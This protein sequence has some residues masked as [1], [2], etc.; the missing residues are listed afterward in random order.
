MFSKLGNDEAGHLIGT[1]ELGSYLH[2]YSNGELEA[3]PV[4]DLSRPERVRAGGQTLVRYPVCGFYEDGKISQDEKVDLE[5]LF[6]QG[7]R[8]TRVMEAVL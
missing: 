8:V 5:E 2:K 4:F 1:K 7:N 3:Y 6:S